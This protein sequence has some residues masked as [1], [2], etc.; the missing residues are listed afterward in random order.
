MSRRDRNTTAN[1]LVSML[2]Y[3]REGNVEAADF[4]ERLFKQQIE[5]NRRKGAGLRG[6]P[7]VTA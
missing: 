1:L 2:R 4:T 5:T 6:R 3:R 7:G